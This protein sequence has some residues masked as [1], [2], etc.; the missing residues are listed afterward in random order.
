MQGSR[1][2]IEVMDDID[3][4]QENYIDHTLAREVVQLCQESDSN[5]VFDRLLRHENGYFMRYI[6]PWL[7]ERA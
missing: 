1:D 5:W 2:L 3:A 6:L 4:I 7:P